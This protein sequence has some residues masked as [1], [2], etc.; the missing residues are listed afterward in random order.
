MSDADR[1]ALSYSQE[2]TF[3]VLPV[4]TDTQI[5]FSMTAADNSINDSGSGFVSAGFVAGSRI[6]V[7]GFTGDTDNNQNYRIDSVAAGKMI[8][9]DF[10][11]TIVDDAAGES[12]TITE[13]V[14]K[15]IRYTSESLGQDTDTVQ[16]AEIR[17][18]RQVVDIVRTNVSASGDINFE[19]SYGSFDDFMEAALQSAAW[20][21]EV[22]DTDTVH[23]MASGD[24]SIND[25]GSGYVSDGFVANQWIKVSG[26][27]GGNAAN[28][29]YFK[30]STVAAGKMVLVGGTVV[31]ESAG[32][33]VTI[34]MGSQI[35]NGTTF[36]SFRF[37]K[38]FTDLTNIFAN[39]DGSPVEGFALSVATETIVTGTFSFLGT[40]EV[41]AAATVAVGGSEAANTNNILNNVD[42]VPKFH[43]NYG[44]QT[45]LLAFTHALSANLR[46]RLEVG[47]LGPQS[48]GSGKNAI[49]GT[50]QMYFST[51]AIMDKY[52]AFTESV[53]SIVLEDD[54]GRAYVLDY[55]AIKYTE[56]RR[57]GGGENTDIIADMSWT[58][59]RD[60]TEG[61]MV[62]IQRWPS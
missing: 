43:D 18:D 49:T 5:T 20:S 54:N 50:V 13:G 19:L 44:E 51:I 28:N 34:T 45:E 46:Q 17:N 12:V 26:F 62:R 35:V 6:A 32:D 40:T 22:S 37:E 61:I 53:L 52:L 36:R 8:L 48:F 10:V 16:S 55:P 23:S 56:G 24:N 9:S 14:F 31:T 27:L 39:L 60:A 30:I 47:Q 15:D 57:V 38:E 42:N 21:T 11:N 3:G 1:L 33:S 4:A 41:S 58:A 25:S 2:A 59:K 29:S 7:S